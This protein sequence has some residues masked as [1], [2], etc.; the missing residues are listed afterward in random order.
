M[1]RLHLV[2]NPDPAA[3]GGVHTS[4]MESLLAGLA[5][6]F[7]AGVTPGPLLA[8]VISA[9]LARGWRRGVQAAMAPLITDL[10]IIILSITVVSVVPTPVVAALSGIGALVLAWFAVET[11]RE[12]QI[13]EIAVHQESVNTDRTWAKAALVNVL[14][15]SPWLFWATVGG[16]ILVA[17]WRSEPS[18]AAAFLIGFY[19]LLVGMKVALAIGLGASRHKLSTRT[20]RGILM[21][22]AGLMLSLAV[23]LALR[24]VQT[25]M[26]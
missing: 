15:P 4:A 26:G 6:G 10:P 2:A 20:Y 16:P 21:G 22:A 7:S 13:A 17:A 25:L 24:A 19:L 12:A 1:Q 23:L 9:T 8:L 18:S 14:S 3:D 5:L 11:Y